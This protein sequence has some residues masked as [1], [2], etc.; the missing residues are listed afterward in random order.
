M[1]HSPR[2]EP[3]AL[4]IEQQAKLIILVVD[5]LEVEAAKVYNVYE[6]LKA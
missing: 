4:R 2:F 3:V 6:E 5:L 1:V